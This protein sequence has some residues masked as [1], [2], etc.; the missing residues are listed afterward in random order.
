MTMK[1]QEPTEWDS[2][3]RALRLLEHP[4]AMWAGVG[5]AS[6]VVGVFA[7]RLAIGRSSITVPLLVLGG[8]AIMAAAGFAAWRRPAHPTMV[9]WMLPRLALALIAG[10]VL[11]GTTFGTKVSPEPIPT[12]PSV[13]QSPAIACPP[14]SDH[15]DYRALVQARLRGDTLACIYE[16]IGGQL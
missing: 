7:D 15:E 2:D 6:V 8:V 1:P 5:A 12:T 9:S 3:D 14:E 16:Y 13:P 4:A 10:G 11:L